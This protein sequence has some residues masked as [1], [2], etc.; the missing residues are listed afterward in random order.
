MVMMEDANIDAPIGES[1]VRWSPKICRGL[2]K[3]CFVKPLSPKGFKVFYNHNE[4]RMFRP[5]QRL[6]LL[7]RMFEA[8]PARWWHGNVF[9]WFFPSKCKVPRARWNIENKQTL[10]PTPVFSGYQNMSLYDV[11]QGYHQCCLSLMQPST[12][13]YQKSVICESPLPSSPSWNWLEVMLQSVQQVD[14]LPRHLWGFSLESS[15]SVLCV[16]EDLQVDLPNFQ[17]RHTDRV[18]LYTV[19]YIHVLVSIW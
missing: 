8:N 1:M 19:A 10:L 18:L 7:T 5:F 17:P 6:W 14:K 15:F 12:N 16:G 4:M 11:F 9:L 3:M 13:I 2:L